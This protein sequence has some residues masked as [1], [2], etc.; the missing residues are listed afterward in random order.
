MLHPIEQI[1]IDFTYRGINRAASQVSRLAEALHG[2]TPDRRMLSQWDLFNDTLLAG[3]GAMAAL[4]AKAARMASDLQQARVAFTVFT[5]SVSEANKHIKEMMEFAAVTPFQYTQVERSSRALQ[6][7]GMTA[8]EVMGYLRTIG[9]LA[10]ATGSELE[11][12]AQAVAQIKVG[13]VGVGLA[14]LR[15]YG[16]PTGTIQQ[17][18]LQRFGYEGDIYQAPPNLVLKAFREVSNQKF[19]GLMEQQMKTLDGAISNL[20]DN[21]TIL[22]RE[23][24]DNLAKTL[25]PTIKDI[26]NLIRGFRDWD[27]VTKAL[28][29]RTLLFGGMASALTGFFGTLMLGVRSYQMLAAAANQAAVAQNNVAASAST[30]GGAVAGGSASAAMSAAARQGPYTIPTGGAVPISPTT[31]F[32]VFASPYAATLQNIGGGTNGVRQFWGNQ[33][34]F[35]RNQAAG[36][37]RIGVAMSPIIG[38]MMGG[39]MGSRIGAGIAMGGTTE[40]GNEIARLQSEKSIAAVTGNTAAMDSLSEKIDELESSISSARLGGAATGGLLGAGIVGAGLMGITM[41]NPVVGVGLTAALGALQVSAEATAA[42][43]TELKNSVIESAAGYAK[44]QAMTNPG[45]PNVADYDVTNP[46]GKEQ[47]ARAMTA[48][49]RAIGSE[50]TLESENAQKALIEHLDFIT[51]GP[52]GEVGAAERLAGMSKYRLRSGKTMDIP[53]AA[54]RALM[55]GG[56]EEFVSQLSFEQRRAILEDEMAEA[57]RLLSG[58]WFQRRGVSP[59][60]K[61]FMEGYEVSQAGMAEAG[62]SAAS[63]KIAGVESD[64]LLVERQL[65]M[66]KTAAGGSLPGRG[67]TTMTGLGNL[68]LQRAL[69]EAGISPSTVS[70]ELLKAMGLGPER[71]EELRANPEAMARMGAFGTF[72][73]TPE[74]AIFSAKELLAKHTR[75]AAELLASFAS[76]PESDPSYFTVRNDLYDKLTQVMQDELALREDYNRLININMETIKTFIM[77]IREKVG[78]E[79][80]KPAGGGYG[81]SLEGYAMR[82]EAI[83]NV[84]AESGVI[85]A[86]ITPYLIRAQIRNAPDTAEAQ[87]MEAQAAQTALLGQQ[88]QYDAV[89]RIFALNQD[90][91][92]GHRARGASIYSQYGYQEALSQ[93]AKERESAYMGGYDQWMGKAAE[94]ANRSSDLLR[95]ITATTP[96]SER[97]RIREEARLYSA[98][99]ESA[100]SQ[101][102][103]ELGK[104]QAAR[105]AYSAAEEEKL[106]L[107]MFHQYTGQLGFQRQTM[108]QQLLGHGMGAT[109]VF[110][111]AETPGT[112]MLQYTQAL[113]EAKRAY[114]KLYDPAARLGEGTEEMLQAQTE[115]TRSLETL[116]SAAIALNESWKELDKAAGD[117][118]SAIAATAISTAA[119]AG[120][121]AFGMGGFRGE[122]GRTYEQLAGERTAIAEE[123]NT[124]SYRRSAAQRVIE[125][126]ALKAAAA[127]VDPMR[128]AG[129]LAALAEMEGVKQA[130]KGLEAR[131]IV[132]GREGFLNVQQLRAGYMEEGSAGAGMIQSMYQSTGINNPLAFYLDPM[133]RSSQEQ[134]MK[135]AFAQ[136]A[137]YFAVGM[138]TEGYRA[139]QAGYEAR[140][141]LNIARSPL[142][143]MGMEIFGGPTGAAE[144]IRPLMAQIDTA[145]IMGDPNSRRIILEV[146]FPGGPEAYAPEIYQAAVNL[147][148]NVFMSSPGIRTIGGRS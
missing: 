75:E 29:G 125:T 9:D 111:A 44:R 67:M 122:F 4:G 13:N 78:P 32:G 104:A 114:E 69:R 16:M 42:A 146:T 142:A 87:R 48:Y 110:G 38:G 96:Q 134:I 103:A 41:A 138:T 128:S 92:A 126:E 50:Y 31:R 17:K 106:R 36:A 143:Q 23:I 86:V 57:R 117:L 136:A 59:A 77:G 79:Y 58:N 19:G 54:G 91:A 98:A 139:M 109:G 147:M 56:S 133:Y 121:R 55:R 26:T 10:S 68:E 130:E 66:M 64:R 135:N 24:G 76:M 118:Y 123:R 80:N 116:R 89:S 95:S 40:A 97:D 60:I 7:Y 141:Q 112:A 70:V 82:G 108:Q 71:A 18:M 124:L 12:V 145:R 144:Y 34:A 51:G 129:Y 2:A 83:E 28:I 47:F 84:N 81:G 93:Q 35:I 53:E 37:G 21:I 8:K 131:G 73:A 22:G 63:E 140:K 94:L 105:E 72:S 39:M 99:S 11:Y 115:Y 107:Y 61:A 3:G 74:L 100:R 5:R 46:Q 65:A 15:A 127:G 88:Q 113:N 137:D 120:E 90:V 30:A 85:G 14:T 49:T 132:A 1:Q 102:S 119:L 20:I 43:M 101:A 27:A 33:A 25:T 148:T 6:A 52:G 62:A 45:A